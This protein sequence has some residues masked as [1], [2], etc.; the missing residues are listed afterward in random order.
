MKLYQA[1]LWERLF[2]SEVATYYD[3]VLALS[4]PKGLGSN[5]IAG[6]W[7]Q[8]RSRLPNPAPG[9]IFLPVSRFGAFSEG[10]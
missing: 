9:L 10:N 4:N 8:T 7:N 6:Q 1:S 3:L 5:T 2:F